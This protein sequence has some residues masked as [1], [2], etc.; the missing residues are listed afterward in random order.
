ME[1][2]K[3]TIFKDIY[4]VITKIKKC[5]AKSSYSI[6]MNELY[7]LY[8]LCDELG[9]DDY[10]KIENYSSKSIEYD[11]SE[12][13]FAY[14]VFNNYDYYL[15][16]SENYKNI[17]NEKYQNPSSY[18]IKNFFHSFDYIYLVRDFLHDYDP[19]ILRVFDEMNE[20]G[21][22]FIVSVNHRDEK[23]MHTPAYTSFSFG[24]F[25]P[26]I[27]LEGENC[28]ADLI[29][30]VHEIAH[31]TEYMNSSV[32]S[33]KVLKQRNYNCLNE[34][35]S[36][37]LQNLFIRH[38]KDIKFNLHDT[39]TAE[40]G[41][42]YTYYLWINKLHECLINLKE[43]QVLDL[44]IIEYLNYTFGI[45]IGYHF[46]ERYLED[47]DKTKKEIADFIILNGQYNLSDML[48]K[49]NL[50]DELIDSKVLKKYI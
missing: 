12:I 21:R 31:T 17:D 36:Y 39:K 38:L 50:K 16:F 48:E 49:F 28:V 11:N 4:N 18:A 3:R 37:F 47:P 46:I 6:L 27:V 19:R 43:K 2:I 44:N 45:A 24:S 33:N 13:T 7:T 14:E 32:V 8:S 35:Y 42:N 23:D 41:Y 22:I 10:P 20:D 9:I 34:V 5:N 26:Y 40:L 25:K 15:R 1:E 29:N 30:I